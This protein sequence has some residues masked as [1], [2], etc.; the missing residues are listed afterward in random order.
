MF[1]VAFFISIVFVIAK[2]LHGSQNISMIHWLAVI[3]S[4]IEFSN[5]YLLISNIATKIFIE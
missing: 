1:P 5:I 3:V 2:M 4:A